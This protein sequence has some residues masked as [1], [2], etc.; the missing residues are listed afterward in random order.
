MKKH[1]LHLALCIFA[2]SA[3]AQPSD[4]Q[5]KQELIAKG[6][7]EVRFTSDKGT[8]HTTVTEKYY[9]RSVESKWKTDYSSIYR[10]ERSD[11][12][13]NYTGGK[14]LFGKSYL[15]SNWFDGIPNPTES[16]IIKTLE[17]SKVGY[18]NAVI[19]KP[20]FKLADNPKWNWHTF[21]SVEFMVEVVFYEKTSNTDISKKKTTFPV[22]LYRNTGNGQ[23]DPNTKTYFKDG[24][25]LNVT[26]PVITSSYGKEE[27]LEVKKYSNEDLEKTKTIAET[28][29]ESNAQE[30]LKSLGNLNIPEFKTD[31]EAI[32]W[33]HN[34]MR[35]GNENKIELMALNML[36]VFHF[37]NGSNALLNENG[38]S[39]VNNLKKVAKNYNLLYCENPTIKHEQEN[40]MQFYD[41]ENESHARIALSYENKKYK[42]QDLDF[43]FDASSSK[44]NACKAAGDSNCGKAI[45]TKPAAAAEKFNTGDLVTVNWNGQGKDFYNG[46]IVKTDQFDANRYFIEFESIQSAWINAKQITKR[47]TN[48]TNTSSTNVTS[49]AATESLSIGDKVT[50]NWKNSGKWFPGKIEKIDEKD[51]NRFFIKYDDGDQ[52]WT[53]SDKIKKK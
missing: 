47:S 24:D 9:E 33:I 28:A 13:Y 3:V 29:E 26:M 37:E 51:S 12:R 50:A 53:T 18:Q 44:V 2:Y 39:L 27:I 49:A 30:H 52:E 22:R 31:K 15:A 42:I 14:W 34:L 23:H 10:W 40:M 43:Y 7:I 21:N 46:K 17:T 4:A 5:I 45:D 8:V 25:W 38:K 16:E 1:L 20:K 6:A 11:R 41:R 36:T 48:T 35:E 32:V 19:E